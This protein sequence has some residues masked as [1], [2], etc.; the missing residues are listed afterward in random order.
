[1]GQFS[2]AR[3]AVWTGAQVTHVVEEVWV[4][5]TRHFS[6][7]TNTRN[8]WEEPDTLLYMHNART[9]VCMHIHS[10]KPS[11]SSIMKNVRHINTYDTYVCKQ[12]LLSGVTVGTTPVV[13]GA[14]ML[15]YGAGSSHLH[16][17]EGRYKVTDRPT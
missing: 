2:V 13:S 15:M 1:M 3:L 16:G 9:H 14:R 17:K 8:C 6:C 5:I 4:S 11:S 7:I 12:V 10:H